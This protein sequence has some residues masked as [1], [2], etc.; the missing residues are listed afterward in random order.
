[1]AN[2]SGATY[3]CSRVPTIAQGWKRK[4][5][6]KRIVRLIT[7]GRIM[8]MHVCCIVS[9]AGNKI[10]AKQIGGLSAVGITRSMHVRGRLLFGCE[11]IESEK[12]AR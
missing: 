4:G 9:S 1:M 5:E 7:A 8:N 12:L 2:R 3:E 6:R 11:Q 10:A